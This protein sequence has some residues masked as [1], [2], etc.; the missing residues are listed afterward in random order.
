M[1]KFSDIVEA[2]VEKQLV[3]L[4]PKAP[5][6]R[7]FMDIHKIKDTNKKMLEPDDGDFEVQ[8]KVKTFNRKKNHFGN[9]MDNSI[10]HY[11]ERVTIND[12]LPNAHKKKHTRHFFDKQGHWLGT[13][14]NA[15]NN[16]DAMK[17]F[18]GR[19]IGN[20]HRSKVSIVKEAKMKFKVG[21][22]IHMGFGAKGGAGFRGKVIEIDDHGM[23]KIERPKSE[24]DK[25]YPK[26][27]KG[28][29]TNCTKEN[30]E[31]R[32][33]LFSEEFNEAHKQVIR[34]HVGKYHI[35]DNDEDVENDIRK[36]LKQDLPEDFKKKC[37]QH[38]QS[39]HLDNQKLYHGIQTGFF[40]ECLD[41]N[42][43]KTPKKTPKKTFDQKLGEVGKIY[44]KRL[45]KK[46][47]PRLVKQL[48]PLSKLFKEE[49]EL[50]EKYIGFKKLADKIE[51][52]GNSK[53]SANKIA[54]FIGRKKYGKK[55]FA[56]MSKEEVE[57]KET[58]SP[59]ATVADYI[60]DFVNSDN[61]KFKGKSK[62]KR[63][64]Q[65]IATWY[66]KHRKNESKNMEYTAKN[67]L[68]AMLDRFEKKKKVKPNLKDSKDKK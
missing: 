65:A 52:K 12:R 59:D 33:S 42:E 58:M 48:A 60:H 68:V 27:Y 25:W 2:K 61:P 17:N 30:F 31:I 44:A 13:T 51:K 38:A 20:V 41:L 45:A 24:L 15:K 49:V 14:N 18:I 47:A 53:E 10:K 9:D 37:I 57:I 8:D 56:A 35:N 28:H 22:N 19:A 6:E 62:E 40:E 64:E 43:V 11:D 3:S 34:F 16:K 5:G 4:C 1:K 23:V 7:H 21:D 29:Y 26:Q 32:E 50:D 67:K 36:T 63:R 66:S 39:C 46:A 54:A 55:K